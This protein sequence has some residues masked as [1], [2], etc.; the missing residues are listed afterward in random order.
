MP[1]YM[2]ENRRYMREREDRMLVGHTT[3]ASAC[4]ISAKQS[5]RV[6]LTSTLRWEV[7]GRRHA[8]SSTHRAHPNVTQL[9][10][11]MVF[12]VTSATARAVDLSDKCTEAI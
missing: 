8:N 9:A 7:L 3:V 4:M 6:R 2:A 12:H 1:K 10:S 5:R 11:C